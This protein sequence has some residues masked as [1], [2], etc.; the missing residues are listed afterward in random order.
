MPAVKTSSNLGKSMKANKSSPEDSAHR[1]SCGS[2][3]SCSRP[4]VATKPSKR[5]APKGKISS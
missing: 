1:H 3:T 5:A 2:C 4:V